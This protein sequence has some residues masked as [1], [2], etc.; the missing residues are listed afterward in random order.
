MYFSK[1]L[2]ASKWAI[3]MRPVSIES[4]LLLFLNR[5]C[6]RTFLPYQN[7][8]KNFLCSYRLLAKLE[9]HLIFL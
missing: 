9:I 8:K 3:T 2:N 5:L 6:N 4:T 7:L 1:S